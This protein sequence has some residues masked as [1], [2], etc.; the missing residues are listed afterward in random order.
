MERSRDL[1]G[2]I[3]PSTQDIKTAFHLVD[4]ATGEKKTIR[5]MSD[6]DLAA[7]RAGF[8]EVGGSKLKAVVTRLQ[9][10]V[11]NPLDANMLVEM[12]ES[13]M[14]DS[15]L[16]SVIKYEQNRRANVAEITT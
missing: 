13:A 6:A 3:G 4:P 8:A 2:K 15:A 5:E 11:R 12:I 1:N 7:Y 14:I 10:I 9:L 16:L